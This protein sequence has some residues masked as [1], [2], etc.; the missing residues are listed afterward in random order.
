MGDQAIKFLSVSSQRTSA[1]LLMYRFRDGGLEIFLAHPGGPHFRRKDDGHWTLPKGEVQPG[2]D[3]LATAIREFK[4]ETGLD[5][6]GEFIPLGSVRQK[7]GKIVFGW[8]F[9]GDWEPSR[10]LVS[11]QYQIEWPP[12][13]GH[14]A[15]FPEI[16][17]AEFFP[18]SDARRKMKET[19]WPFVERLL[20]ALGDRVPSDPAR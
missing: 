3:L 4:E 9:A 17:R 18:L 5:A 19:Q 8:A 6:S 15:E 13:S 1:G 14:L 10:P 11:N 7:G 12:H 16:D 2:E 20:A